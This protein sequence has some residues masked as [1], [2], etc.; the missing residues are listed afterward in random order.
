[1]RDPGRFHRS[2]TT[3]MSAAMLVIGIALIVR[4]LAAHGSLDA[5]GILLGALFMLGGGLRL[6]AQ[7]RM[8]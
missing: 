4:T 2:A 7:N 3:A 1:M 6:Y 8:R 5:A